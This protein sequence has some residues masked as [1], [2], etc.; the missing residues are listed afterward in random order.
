MT[1]RA[2]GASLLAFPVRQS[3]VIS[4]QFATAPRSR[5][6]QGR[7]ESSPRSA[8]GMK[9]FSNFIWVAAVYGGGCAKLHLLFVDST[10]CGQVSDGTNTSEALRF[11][12]NPLRV[13]GNIALCVALAGIGALMIWIPNRSAGWDQPFWGWVCL[14]ICGGL[15][16]TS[17]WRFFRSPVDSIVLS[18]AGIRVSRFGPKIIPWSEVQSVGERTIRFN[19]FLTLRLTPEGH[20]LIR[21]SRI[22]RLL[23]GIDRVLGIKYVILPHAAL[24]V[25]RRDFQASLAAYAR[26]QGVHVEYEL[27]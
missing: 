22:S 8:E 23:Y 17:V 15:A 24:D 18:P 1:S 19:K 11:E 7:P 10:D 12:E 9:S 26:A 2:T 4:W 16:A 21:R 6:V 13:L 25:S 27:A 20:G 5:Q 14:L 3:I